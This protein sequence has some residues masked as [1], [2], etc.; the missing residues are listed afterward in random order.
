MTDRGVL[1]GAVYKVI[2]PY[3][4]GHSKSK[5]QNLG[6]KYR[7]YLICGSEIRT[8]R[9]ARQYSTRSAVHPLL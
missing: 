6:N 5:Y 4:A 3:A 7:P 8:E 1:K 9:W 2:T